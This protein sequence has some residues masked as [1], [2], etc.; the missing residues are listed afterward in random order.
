MIPAGATVDVIQI[1]CATGVVY[2]RVIMEVSPLLI[3]GLLIA[4]LA[5]FIVVRSGY[6]SGLPLTNRA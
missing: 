2:P 4:L 3:A 6:N 5:G 1:D